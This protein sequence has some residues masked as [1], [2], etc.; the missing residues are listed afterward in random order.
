NLHGFTYFKLLTLNNFDSIYALKIYV[1]IYSKIDIPQDTIKKANKTFLINGKLVNEFISKRD[2]LNK[3]ISN[4]KFI[5][6]EKIKQYYITNR[7]NEFLLSLN[8]DMENS[9]YKIGNIIQIF[10]KIALNEINCRF[11]EGLKQIISND[12]FYMQIKNKNFNYW[13]FP[14]IMI[15]IIW[16]PTSR[17]L[18]DNP[19]KINHCMLQYINIKDIDIDALREYSTE[20]IDNLNFHLQDISKNTNIKY[21]YTDF[22]DTLAFT[23]E[24]PK[25]NII[26]KSLTEDIK[27]PNKKNKKEVTLQIGNFDYNDTEDINW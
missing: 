20:D 19:K 18:A 1:Y 11:K 17:V 4:Y 21:D 6:I 13:P 3:N 15:R 5:D 22:I 2:K 23:Y 10:D 8:I 14:E 27:K 9:K 25:H 26:E 12:T 7:I 24:L 16:L